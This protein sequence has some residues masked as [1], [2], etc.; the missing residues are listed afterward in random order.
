MPQDFAQ[1]I[2][3][4]HDFYLMTGTGAATLVGLLFVAVTVN[5]NLLRGPDAHHRRVWARHTFL[6]FI[7]VLFISLIFLMPS[8]SGPGI[9]LPL[10]VMGGYALYSVL[11]LTREVT[12]AST[13]PDSAYIQKRIV[14][15]ALYA[16]GSYIILIVVALFLLQEQPNQL[17]WLAAA[18]MVLLVAAAGSAWRLL[19]ALIEAGRP[20]LEES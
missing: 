20:D 11:G 1:A 15:E 10:L 6:N 4:W 18:V 8:M 17:Y 12:R 2:E 19:V 7:Y 5:A 9:A 16:G 14:R 13:A 3:G